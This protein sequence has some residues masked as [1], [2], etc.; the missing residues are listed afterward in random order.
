[1]VNDPVPLH[2][3]V[4]PALFVALEP[5]VIFTAPLVEQVVTA[6]PATDVGA[7]VIVSVLFDVAFPTQGELGVDVNVSVTLPAEISAALGVYVQVVNEVALAN[8]PVPLDVHVVVA[9]LPLEPAV[10]FT[11]PEL[12]QVVTAVPATAVGAAVIVIVFVDVALVHPA[13]PVAVRTRV[14]LPAAISAA[15]GVYVQSVK[16]VALA[17]VPVPL[18]V[19]QVIPVLLVELDPAVIF[20]APEFEQVVTAVPATAVG[21]ADTVTVAV[22]PAL[23]AL[24]HPPVPANAI[25][26]IVTVVL[27]LFVKLDVV[28]V[29]EPEAKTMVAVLPV[30]VL[31][32]VKL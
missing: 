7:G 4:I 24:L 15:L 18:D 9:P 3:Q 26:V 21:A 29:P 5:A 8:V 1:M 30:A 11:A 12:E 2:V 19:D 20:T 10:I 13:F 16:E 6:V 31:V 23:I 27:P 25:A 17:N 22:F 14:L 32:P 28:N